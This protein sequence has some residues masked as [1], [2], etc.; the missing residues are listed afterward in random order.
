MGGMAIVEGQESNNISILQSPGSYE[1]GFSIGIQYEHQNKLIYVGPEIYLFP[2]LH[3]LPYIHLIGRFGFNV[4]RLGGLRFFAGGRAGLLARNWEA[5]YA[6]LG[7]EI[8]FDYT[9]HNGQ[10][11]IGLSAATDAKTDSKYWGNNDSHTV[12]S[13]F[14]RIGFKF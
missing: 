10:W 1:D 6:I 14:F 9:P 8:G 3:D 12:N 13:G 7:A 2:N 4:I 5:G 11:F